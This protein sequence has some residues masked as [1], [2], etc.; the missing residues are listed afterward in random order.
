L[1]AKSDS[2]ISIV[3][4][5][6]GE[7]QNFSYV[8][9]DQESAEAAVFDPAWDIPKI[10]EALKQRSFHLKFI[11]NTHSHFDHIE[12]NPAL[13]DLANAKIVMSHTSLA[14]KDVAVTD[15]QKLSLGDNVTL[16]FILTPGHSP[17]S[18]C[19]LV[20]DIALITGDT[21]FIGDCGRVDLPEG[22]AS[23]LFD[24]FE[25]IRKLN[26]NLIVYPGHDYGPRPSTTLKEQLEQNYTLAKRERSEFIR[27]MN[28][29]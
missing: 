20:N 21:L 12:G 16:Q 13:H 19:I 29:P 18:M 26:P 27:F 9:G 28:E 17:D 2:K 14:K 6:V 8:V 3:Q 15:G 7:Y 4:L 10:L 11:I 22:N 23:D 5:K 25:K 24:S 1:K